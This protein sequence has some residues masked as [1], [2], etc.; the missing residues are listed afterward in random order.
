MVISLGGLMCPIGPEKSVGVR[1]YLTV[2]G[3]FSAPNVP[4]TPWAF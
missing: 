3:L 1:A 2:I 4:V